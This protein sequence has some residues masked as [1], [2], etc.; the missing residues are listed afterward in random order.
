[1]AAQNC[2]QGLTDSKQSPALEIQI[3]NFVFVLAKFIWTTHPSK[4]LSK[5][6]LGLFKIIGK[7][8]FHFY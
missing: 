6:F 5:K 8:S 2:Y 7:P 4:K 3:G 1:M